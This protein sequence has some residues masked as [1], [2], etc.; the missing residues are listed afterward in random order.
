MNPD[1]VILKIDIND[2][3]PMM[4]QY[5]AIKRENLDSFV[6]FRLGDFYEM[7]FDDALDASR[8]LEIALTGRD[9]GAKE[10]VP[11]CGV[12]YHAANNYIE[13]LV[14]AGF[15]VA[16]VEQVE[17]ATAGKGIV[18]REV[19]QVVT[20]GTIM[21]SN[22]LSEKENNYIGTVS[23]YPDQLMLGFCDLTTGEL[24]LM[25]LPLEDIHIYNQIITLG[26]R[27][28]ILPAELLQADF[29]QRLREQYNIVL[30]LEESSEVSKEMRAKMQQVS[31]VRGQLTLARLLTYLERTQKRSLEHIQQATIYE[32]SSYLQMD[33]HSQ[34]ALELTKTL[35][36]NAKTGSLLWLLDQTKTAMGGR[37]LKKWLERP[38]ID[39]AEI[40]HRHDFVACLQSEYF[41]K[42]EIKESLKFVYDLERLL[43]RIVYENASG[44]E[45]AQLRQSLR[46]LPIIREL[47]L[48]LP[49]SKA[50]DLANGIDTFDELL[51]TLEQGIV[52][53]PPPGIKDGGIIADGF[54]DELDQLRDARKNGKVW[55][56][57]LEAAERERTGIK[58]LKIGYNRVFGYYLEATKAA[59][60]NIDEDKIRH[61]DRK[62][63]L[64]NAERYITPELKEKE[65]LIL[66]AEERMSLLEYEIFVAI[67]QQVKGY[68]QKLQQAA[69]SIATVDVLASFATVSE[70]YNYVRADIIEGHELAIVDGRHP[71]VERVMENAEYVANDCKM[72]NTTD[73]LLITGPNMAGKSTYMRQLADIVIMNQIGCFVPAAKAEL[74]IFESIFTRIG[75]SDDL[76]SGQSTFMVEM[77]EVNMALKHATKNSLILF[78]E[79]G[80]GTATYD[81]MALAQSIL[82]YIHNH[83][84][85]KTLFSTH[86]HEL[87]VLEEQL[88]RLHNVHVSAI[89]ENDQLVFLHKVKDGSVDRS[90]GVHVAQLAHLPNEVIK[91]AQTILGSLEAQRGD[92]KQLDLFAAP[93]N[94]V[95]ASNAVD[96]DTQAVLD[97]LASLDINQLTPLDALN[98]LGSVLAKL[99]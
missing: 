30:S 34:A 5:I 21:E 54:N 38:L 72:N 52:D 23:A 41:I 90:Y 73:I 96:A 51:A 91:R 24:G 84:G 75:A 68:T 42:E 47:I 14:A 37:M 13:R 53:N 25:A 88:T 74:P 49:Y 45:L 94:E 60:A 78:D 87:T 97:E 29:Y 32:T 95:V 9:A 36:G 7:F 39:K 76:F 55:L 62:Q 79:I 98:A 58:T 77:M 66:G 1:P 3:T 86:Y 43:G 2:Y 20:P 40:V 56:A 63:T 57:E 61:Y 27:E 35:R 17:E 85:A 44:K 33:A 59:L 82:E 19:V 31:D 16:I 89:E 81:G 11:M 18:R 4:Q 48:R 80:R 83:I 28:L 8:I 10:R 22:G 93:V 69:D 26:I 99:K 50:H 46:Q 70:L 15:K 6:F 12:P 71:V 92:S 67:R 64:A 65:S